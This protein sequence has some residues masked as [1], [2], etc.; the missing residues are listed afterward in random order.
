MLLS[1]K[2]MNMK[3]RLTRG[4]GVAERIISVGKAESR[5]DPKY[6]MVCSRCAK[7][8]ITGAESHRQHGRPEG[9]QTVAPLCL[10]TTS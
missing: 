4:N 7:A 9:G 5:P 6:L 1:T 8:H 10:Y 2:P 3:K